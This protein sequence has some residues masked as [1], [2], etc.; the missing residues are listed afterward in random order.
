[1]RF[2]GPGLAYEGLVRFS[3]K[4]PTPDGPALALGWN[5]K[6]Q[7]VDSHML[8]PVRWKRPR[9]IF[10]NSMSDLFH[11]ALPFE[12]IAAIFGIMAAAPRHTFLVLTKR[13][14]RALDFFA[15]VQEQ[16][17]AISE[18]QLDGATRGRL[19]CLSEALRWEVNHSDGELLHTKHGADPRGPWPLPNV[20][21]GVSVGNQAEA[22]SFIP[23]ALEFT[24]KVIWVSYEP[25][26]GPVDFGRW[27][28]LTCTHE[29]AYSESDTN[30]T[31]CR[32]CDDARNL[33]WIVCGGES[34][35]DARPFDLAWARSVSKQCLY[36]G[37]PIWM[38]QMGARPHSVEDRITHRGNT[39]SN[40]FPNG[41]FS[42]YLNDRSGSDPMEWPED[43]RLQQLPAERLT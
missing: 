6:V 22:D 4:K 14:Q 20:H 1:M 19:H 39:R 9:R 43:L 32:Q 28:G 26:H 7:R 13:P 31:I 15:W 18:K 12:D 8:D 36:A 5:G 37:V 40:E 42:R 25:A 41:S 3:K 2:S 16:D 30:A 29:D 23:L 33:D 38:K 27:M 21:M 35:R 10:V 24:A 17:A 11:E 34:G